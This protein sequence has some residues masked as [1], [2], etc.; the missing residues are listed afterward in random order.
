VYRAVLSS[1]R[2][3]KRATIIRTIT[4]RCREAMMNHVDQQ[5][6]LIGLLSIENLA[7]ASAVLCW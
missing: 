1:T 5:I 4:S 3:V 7:L 2:R 6:D